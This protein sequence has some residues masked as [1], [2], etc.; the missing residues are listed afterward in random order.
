MKK[1]QNTEKGIGR[2]WRIISELKA[3]IHRETE[4]GYKDRIIHK[5][6]SLN[7]NWKFQTRGPE[8]R[9][10]YTLQLSRLQVF[11]LMQ[12]VF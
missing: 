1:D 8:G 12:F 9:T 3:I 5:K 10:L 7:L 4:C 11:N 6:L 2:R